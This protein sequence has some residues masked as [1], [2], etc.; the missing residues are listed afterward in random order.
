MINVQLTKPISGECRVFV[1]QENGIISCREMRP[2]SYQVRRRIEVRGLEN[3][4]VRFYAEKYCEK[5][6]EVLLNSSYLYFVGESFDGG[7]VTDRYGTYYEVRN[8]SGT[9]IFFMLKRS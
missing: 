5:S 2:I 4:T 6:V 7:Y 3:A 8:I 9:L 1:E